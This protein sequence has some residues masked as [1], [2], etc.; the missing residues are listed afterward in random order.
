MKTISI[1]ILAISL[2]SCYSVRVYNQHAI[3]ESK[4]PTDTGFYTD[5][6]VYVLD[7]VVKSKTWER[8]YLRESACKDCGFYSIEYRNTLGG[9]LRYFFTFGTRR[10]IRIK[11]VCATK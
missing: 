6:V 8:F 3:Y 5:K 10:T 9:C 7:T 4:A 11:Y 2:S 1:F